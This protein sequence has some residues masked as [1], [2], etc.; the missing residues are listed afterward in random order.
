MAHRRARPSLL[1]PAWRAVGFAVGRGATTLL[2]AETS[3]KVGDAITRTVAEQYDANIR[4]MYEAK[5]EKDE[6]EVREVH[7]GACRIERVL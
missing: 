3:A 1:L 2:P 6:S 7:V 4:S 5:I